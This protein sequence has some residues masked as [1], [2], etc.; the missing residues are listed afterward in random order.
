[1]E[2]SGSITTAR[3]GNIGRLT[4]KHF[5]TFLFTLLFPIVAFATVSEDVPFKKSNGD[6]ATSSFDYTFKCLT[7]DDLEVY[8]ID[9]SDYSEAIQTLTTNYTLTI[10]DDGDG[11]TVVFTSGALNSNQQVAILCRTDLDQTADVPRNGRLSAVALETALDRTVTQVSR[12]DEEV[13]RSLKLKIGDPLVV[14]GYDGLFITEDATADRQ[15][16]LVRWN[17][18]GTELEIAGID[19]SDLSDDL[20]SLTTSVAA[21]STSATNAATSATAAA[22]SATAAASSATAAASS[23]TDAAS[24]A[25]DA[26]NSAASVNFTWLGNWTTATS[27][28]IGNIVFSS[29]SSYIATADHTS[30][31]TT[32]AGIGASWETVWDLFAQ[33]GSS[34]AGTGDMLYAD[35]LEFMSSDSTAR[36][37]LGVAIGSDVQA[38]DTAL[39]AI[40]NG[41]TPATDTCIQFTSSTGAQAYPCSD[42]FISLSSASNNAA[43]FTAVKQDASTSAT[44]VVELATDAEC[45]AGSSS[46]LA[47]TP[48]GV[49][50]YITDNV[51]AGS[52]TYT[53]AS[54]NATSS[55]TLLSSL[56]GVSEIEIFTDGLSRSIGTDNVRIQIGDSGG[57]ETSGYQSAVSYIWTTAAADS[58]NTD[59]TG[60]I[61]LTNGVGST[62][63]DTDC[64]LRLSLVD[65]STLWSIM[66]ICNKIG[67]TDGTNHVIGD[68]SLTGTLTQV[69][70]ISDNNMDGG[71]VAYMRYK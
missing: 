48:S 52:W 2:T 51:S 7:S 65:D 23:A 55:A 26:A 28:S 35:N 9:T 33:Q 30:G 39:D 16:Q 45:S 19:A 13:N 63:D 24:S 70:M 5:V 69:R 62:S 38:W 54:L 18:A 12:L 25:T 56:S 22:S 3:A 49:A 44:G 32:E 14:D 4:M 60:F 71:G 37:N 29:G 46:T 36:T 58:T 41:T 6:D 61:L 50:Q 1:M 42:G 34:G 64:H 31:S 57:F 68:K 21:A 15:D 66:G 27:Y 10:N 8:V 11:G 67:G 47:C 40:A 43:V 53:S 20:A 59:T 17:A